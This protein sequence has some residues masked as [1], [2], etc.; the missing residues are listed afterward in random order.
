MHGRNRDC[1]QGC[2]SYHTSS[3]LPSSDLLNR[4]SRSVWA[5]DFTLARTRDHLL[6]L[7]SSRALLQRMSRRVFVATILSSGTRS[8]WQLC[9]GFSEKVSMF[10]EHL[11]QVHSSMPPI[12]SLLEYRTNSF[13]S[14]ATGIKPAGFSPHSI[15][16]LT[17][18]IPP[19]VLYNC[20]LQ[21]VAI[22]K[23]CYDDLTVALYI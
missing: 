7:P 4:L 8:F 2:W 20:G 11:C 23:Y 22:L 14:E 15:V 1:I 3:N 19:L 5:I 13:D 18:N 16:F 6:L 17:H 10:R 12:C 9:I 21:L